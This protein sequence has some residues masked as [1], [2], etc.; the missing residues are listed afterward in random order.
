M[1][2]EPYNNILLLCDKLFSCNYFFLYEIDNGKTEQTLYE[3][4]S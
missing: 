2:P 3:V 1:F 4:F